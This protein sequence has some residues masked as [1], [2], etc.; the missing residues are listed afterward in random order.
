MNTPRCLVVY[1]SYH[2][3]NTERLAKAIAEAWNADMFS[4]EQANPLE[5]DLYEWIA[6]GAGIDS[7]HH[8]AG[9]LE[10]AAKMPD[11]DGKRVFLFSTCGLYTK[12]KMTDDHKPLRTIL[13]N[14]GYA[15]VGEFSCLGFNTNSFLKYFGGLN[16]GRPNALDISN[17]KR[18]AEDILK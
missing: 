9:L 11:G 3:Q 8:Y 7:G 17:A 10:F 6:L 4:V 1:Q 14:K 15:V 2:H 18:Y 12:Q 13:Q 5:I 16:K